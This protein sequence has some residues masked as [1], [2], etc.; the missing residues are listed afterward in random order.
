MKV[1]IDGRTVTGRFT[2]DRTYWLNMLRS[3]TALTGRDESYC[4]YSRLPIPAE[5]IPAHPQWKIESLSAVNDRL[6]TMFAFPSALRRDGA[7]VAHTQ[8]TIPIHTPCPTITSVHDISF[9]LYPS[10]FPKKHRLL[11]NLAVPGAMRRAARIITLSESSRRDI[12]RIYGIPPEKIHAIHLAA[13]PEY[14]PIPKEIARA[15]VNERYGLNDPYVIAV[16]VLQ[17]RK[18]LALLLEA[19]AI[20]KRRAK[21]AHRLVITG[22]AGWDYEN[23]GV[24]AGRLGITESV[25]FTGYVAD[26]DLPHLY[27]A[28]EVLAFPSL[29]EGFGLPPLEAMACGTPALVSDAPAMPEVAGDGAWVLPVMSPVAWADAIAALCTDSELRRSWAQRGIRRAAQFSWER[30]AA[31][32]KKVYEEAL[33]ASTGDYPRDD[34]PEAA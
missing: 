8:Y 5:T 3:L 21:L 14:Q 31:Q 11:L 22:K 10:W 1:G 33:H 16:G 7:E 30:T 12:I 23:L 17:P 2:G 24:L 18:N 27:S 25:Q 19:F 32:T 29:Y 15:A 4:V 13:G 9:R 20:A 6:W 34:R 28:A 26:E